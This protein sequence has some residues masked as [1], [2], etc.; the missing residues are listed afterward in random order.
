MVAVLIIGLGPVFLFLIRPVPVPP[1]PLSLLLLLPLPAVTIPVTVS[2]AVAVALTVTI[3]VL[4]NPV[5]SVGPTP[6]IIL[7]LLVLNLPRLLPDLPPILL[8]FL[9]SS[10]CWV[11]SISKLPDSLKYATEKEKETTEL[12]ST[13]WPYGT[14]IGTT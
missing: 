12:S 3:I 9:G 11:V 4:V 7:A 10:F 13:A 2:V 14:E 1:V 8:G 6:V 5:L